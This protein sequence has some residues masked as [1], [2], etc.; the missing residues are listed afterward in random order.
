MTGP[1][2]IINSRDRVNILNANGG[3]LDSSGNAAF[4]M[5][6]LDN[7]IFSPNTIA[8]GEIER[9]ILL[10]EWTWDTLTSL[11]KRGSREVK[12]DVK[13]LGKVT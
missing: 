11:P 8:V 6:I 1:T 13:N 3:T 9:H 5:A 12:I 2:G 10:F 7:V 4:T